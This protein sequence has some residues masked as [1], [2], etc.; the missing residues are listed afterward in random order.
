MSGDT[1]VVVVGGVGVG[2]ALRVPRALAS[3]LGGQREVE[4]PVP[5]D[6]TLGGLLDAL[7]LSHPLLERRVR[8]ET[9]T[10]RRFVN[11]YVAGTDIRYGD[12]LA[13]AVSGGVSVEVV[14]SVAGG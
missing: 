9:G 12:G 5:R 6:G 10:V 11:V 13:T 14:Q 7:R 8:D 3:D 1:A 4:L 2:V